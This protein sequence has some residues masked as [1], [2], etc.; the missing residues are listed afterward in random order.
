MTEPPLC[1]VCL[2]MTS[3]CT[4]AEILSSNNSNSYLTMEH[5]GPTPWVLS[6][7]EKQLDLHTKITI[8]CN[9]SF[10]LK[11]LV[12]SGFPGSLIDKC[13]VE[14]LGIPRIKL[15]HP[16]LLVNADHLMNE[17]ITHIVQ[18]DLYISPIK[19]M[20][21]FA[22][23]NL[24]K[25]GEFLGFDWLE[26]LNPVINWKKHCVTFPADPLATTTELDKDNK[27]L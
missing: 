17:C 13:L 25:A 5:H 8:P 10:S 3:N 22:V 9:A 7:R 24:G 27:V 6:T 2:Y 21:I 16:K 19:D 20:V 11:M 15:P 23:T 1:S 14:K 4:K 26:R 12:D 18:L